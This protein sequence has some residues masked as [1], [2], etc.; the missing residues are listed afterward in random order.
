MSQYQKGKNIHV[1]INIHK[2]KL[3]KKKII[4]NLGDQVLAN[5]HNGKDKHF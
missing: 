5:F 1:G 4:L 3:V 2:I